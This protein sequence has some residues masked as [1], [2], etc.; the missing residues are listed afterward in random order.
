MLRGR[1]A[2]LGVGAV[3]IQGDLRIGMG[4]K[5]AFR[6]DFDD[7]SVVGDAGSIVV[8]SPRGAMRPDKAPVVT[9]TLSI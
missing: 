3:T 5:E 6:E 1:P 4:A 2:A 7:G 9:Q 8:A